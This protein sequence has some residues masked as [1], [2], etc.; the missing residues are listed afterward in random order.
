M[1]PHDQSVVETQ[2]VL[3]NGHDGLTHLLACG[4]AQWT[5]GR[6]DLQPPLELPS[7][8]GRTLSE[9]VIADRGW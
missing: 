7:V 5:G 9:E 4:A 6:P 3:P 8:T 1:N 2:S